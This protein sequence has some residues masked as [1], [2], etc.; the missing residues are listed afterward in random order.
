MPGIEQQTV[1]LPSFAHSDK[2]VHFLC[3]SEQCTHPSKDITVKKKDPL[4]QDILTMVYDNSAG[5]Y[6]SVENQLQFHVNTHRTFLGVNL[7]TFAINLSE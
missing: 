3:L 5:L 2:D 1:F 6:L 7:L 4:L